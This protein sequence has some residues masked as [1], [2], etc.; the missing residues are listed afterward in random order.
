LGLD[1][2]ASRAGIHPEFVRRLVALGL[3]EPATDA[4]GRWWFAPPQVHTV[5]RIQR[6]RSGLS[7]NYAAIGLVVD[8]LDRIE[9]MEAALHDAHVRVP[10]TAVHVLA[11]ARDATRSDHGP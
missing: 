5:A 11:T 9:L 1:G 10:A 8:L 2:F 3:L 7:I 4:A 6:L